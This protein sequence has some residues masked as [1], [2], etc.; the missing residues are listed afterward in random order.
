MTVCTV[1]LASAVT[2]AQESVAAKS[3]PPH[4]QITEAFHA[5][6]PPIALIAHVEGEVTL[7]ADLRGDGTVG[8]VSV[9]SG[10]Q[11]LRAVSIES[12]ERNSYKCEACTQAGARV[13]LI[14]SF[15][16]GPAITCEESGIDSSYPRFT[17][18]GDTITVEAQP[19]GT[20]DYAARLRVRSAKCLFLWR[21]GFS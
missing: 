14:Y 18:S 16:L 17:H 15:K 19:W 3:L 21:C 5:T 6:Y 7:V 4:G 13:R 9:E 10:P 20:C 8:E 2:F 11:M 12:A 1:L